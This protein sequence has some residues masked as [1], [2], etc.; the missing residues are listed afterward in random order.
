MPY[1]P[2][3]LVLYT[4]QQRWDTLACAGFPHMITPNLD[5][6]AARGAL[7]RQAYCNSPVCMPSR[8]SMLTGRYPSALGTT[9]NGIEFPEAQPHLGTWLKAHGYRTANIG[10]LHFKNHANRDHRTPHPDYGFDVLTL[11]DEPGCY[12][13]AYIR[14]VRERA[15]DRVDLCRCATPP[16]WTGTPVAG[17]P[18]ETHQPYAFRGPET[19]THSAF[20]AD[21]STAFIRRCAAKQPFFCIAGFY[22]PHCPVN[23]PQRF[24]D[25]YAGR[26]IPPPRMN[27]EEN[28]LGLSHEEWLNVRRAYYALVSHVDDQIGRILA[29]V[30][31]CGITAETVILFT[32]DHGEHLGDHGQVQKGAPGWDSCAHV[33]L[34]LSGPGV[35]EQTQLDG[36]VEGVD[37]APALLDLAGLEVP[38]TVQGRSLVPLWTNPAAES[39]ASMYMEYREPGATAFRSIRTENRKYIRWHDGRESLYDLK[40]DPFELNDIACGADC[41]T[42]AELRGL[43]LGRIFEADNQN[44]NRSGAY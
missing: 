38:P 16:A 35:P 36:F 17:P 25:L 27:P 41:D 24:L 21:Q 1:Q 42:L 8:H 4:D 34:L 37:L 23:P 26:D 14:W 19:L 2:N 15:P 5:R 31:E 44:P 30:E 40:D 39:R 3:I 33:P 22:A 29:C 18:R 9:C 6:L 20:V 11:S 43:L 7:F 10:K 28:R 32:S 13:D 12:E